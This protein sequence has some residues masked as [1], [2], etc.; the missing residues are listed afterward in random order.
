V[1]VLGLSVQQ[2]KN[3]LKLS[4]RNLERKRHMNTLRF[5]N[6]SSFLSKCDRG[7]E[8]THCRYAPSGIPDEWSLG[9]KLL[10]RNVCRLPNGGIN[11]N[12]FCGCVK[13]KQATRL[14][15][16]QIPGE[17]RLNLSLQLVCQIDIYARA[18]IRFF[19][20]HTL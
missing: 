14:S 12:V 9:N 17:P 13:E 5:G 10:S 11:N 18:C 15:L 16:Q 7:Q 3:S 2:I 1:V 4:P 20:D 8:Q 6:G 19:H